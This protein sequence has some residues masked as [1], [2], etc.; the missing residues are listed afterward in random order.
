[1]EYKQEPAFINREK[2]LQTLADFIDK[3]PSEI[4]FMHGPKSSGKTTLLYH[5][6]T[7]L[8][9]K[10][11]IDTKFLNLRKVLIV[12]YKDFLKLFFSPDYNQA[13][14]DVK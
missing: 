7:L 2:E 4:L 1:M 5:F 9:E 3:R 14:G 13:K 8:S 11:K 10:S 12:N 6:L